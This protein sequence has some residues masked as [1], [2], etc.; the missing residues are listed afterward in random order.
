M[1]FTSAGITE[2]AIK[3][4][5]SEFWLQEQERS[6]LFFIVGLILD[7]SFKPEMYFHMSFFS[8]DIC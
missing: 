2:R 1:F 4:K 3:V 7:V 6:R 5:R 8:D